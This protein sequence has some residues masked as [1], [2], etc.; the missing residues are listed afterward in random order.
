MVVLP[1][2][3]PVEVG[4]ELRHWVHRAV[5]VLAIGAWGGGTA[6]FAGH[7][8][9][10]LAL[11]F[12][13][14]PVYYY[15]QRRVAAALALEPAVSTQQGGWLRDSLVWFSPV[16]VL[17]LLVHMHRRK[18]GVEPKAPAVQ[19]RDAADEVRAGQAGRG[20]RS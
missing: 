20:P 4:P 7:D 15:C 14:I 11:L 13:S 5:A 16:V 1:G 12:I 8:S 6:A 17:G 9:L 18:V 10:A 3:S 19:Q 2:Q